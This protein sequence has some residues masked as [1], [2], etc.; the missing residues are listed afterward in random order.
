MSDQRILDASSLDINALLE[1]SRLLIESDDQGFIYNNLLLSLMGK[2]GLGRAAVAVADGSGR[3]IVTHTKG[4]AAGMLGA[5]FT[6]DLR[7]RRGTVLFHETEDEE[8]RERKIA[9]LAPLTFADRTYGV[10]LIGAPLTTRSLG[11]DDITYVSL[12][13]AIAAMALEGCSVRGSL[14]DANRKLERRVQRLRSLFEAS[15]EFNALMDRDAILRLLG[16]TLMGEL[17]V[18]K[19]AVALKTEGIGGGG[20]HLEVNR[21]RGIPSPEAIRYFADND[22]TLVTNRSEGDDAYESRLTAETYALGVRAAIPMDVQG[23][24]RGLLL[25]GERLRDRIDEEDVEYLC[26]VANLAIG[27]LEN[28]RLLEETIE[29]KRLEEDLRIAAQ[30][31]QGLLPKTLPH[32]EGYDIAAR[33]IPTQQVGGDCYDAIELGNGRVLISVADVSGKGTP[34]SLLMANVQAALRALARLDMPLNELAARIN[35]VINENTSADKFITAFFGIIDAAAGTFSYVNAG[36]N[37]PYHFRAGSVEALDVGGLILGIMPTMIPYEV[38]TVPMEPGDLLVLYSDGV[39]EAMSAGREEYG[40]DRLRAMFRD[41]RI[42]GAT[43]AVERALADISRFTEG[44]PQ[45]DDIT[46]VAVRRRG[47]C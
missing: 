32:V 14:R 8:L 44:A 40:D 5:S 47:D 27:A 23:E 6:I 29:K 18:S 15:R 9:Y 28:A 4:A 42:C 3:Y 39:T 13:A 45:S 2:L 12:V 37:P 19:F 30:I 46:I 16:Y 35:D 26:S 17:T 34:A 36:H 11:P 43:E 33:T 20:Y 41:D 10:L 25:I 1:F 21:F 7:D 22:A 31:Q 24:A 38:G